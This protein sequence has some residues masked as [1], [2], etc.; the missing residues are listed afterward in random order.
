MN[1]KYKRMT[2]RTKDGNIT[3]AKNYC[4]KV[5]NNKENRHCL[6]I[7]NC[8]LQPEDRRPFIEIAK[9]CNIKQIR[10]LYFTTDKKQCI[11]NN[12]KRGLD[13]TQWKDSYDLPTE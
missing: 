12:V 2:K 1:D 10:C 3:Q 9:R 6:V 4:K 5:L 11:E 7:D 8:G 13:F